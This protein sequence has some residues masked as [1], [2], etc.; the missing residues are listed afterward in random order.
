MLVSAA[1]AA[2]AG[3]VAWNAILHD[4]GGD[5]FFHD[6]PI[7]VVPVSYQGHGLGRLRDGSRRADPRVRA[8]RA[9]SGRQLA[10]AALLCGVS[11]LVVDVYL[12]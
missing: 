5:R 11:A 1:V 6:A 3:P 4:V 8:L 2:A 9:S 7:V 10:L 12:Y